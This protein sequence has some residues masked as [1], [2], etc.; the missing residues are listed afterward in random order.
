[1]ETLVTFYLETVAEGTRL[2]VTE[3]GFE[4]LPEEVRQTP[5]ARN[6]KGWRIQMNNIA[7][8]LQRLRAWGPSGMNGCSA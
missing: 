3:T 2:T 1:M 8:Y 6:S 4:A 7:E 5:F